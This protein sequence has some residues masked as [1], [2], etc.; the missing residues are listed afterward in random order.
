MT[1]STPLP[2]LYSNPALTGSLSSE[3][4][5]VSA[6][7]SSANFNLDESK[8]R[9]RTLQPFATNIC[10]VSNPIKPAP[11]TTNF[12]PIVGIASLIP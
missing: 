1:P 11:I 9:A 2:L 4:R 10:T 12:S 7:Y 8:S 5:N 3:R 6:P